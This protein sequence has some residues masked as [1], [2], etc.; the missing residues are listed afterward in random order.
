[1]VTTMTR[2]K[3]EALVWYAEET[4]GMKFEKH[5]VS[6]TGQWTVKPATGTDY[7]PQ[8]IAAVKHNFRE[9]WKAYC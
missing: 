4:E 9:E 2:D 8:V 1:M 6:F 7:D 3:A 5:F